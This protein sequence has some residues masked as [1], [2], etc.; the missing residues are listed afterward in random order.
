MLDYCRYVKHLKVISFS[1]YYY[2][3]EIGLT[4]NKKKTSE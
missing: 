4:Y 2:K 3:N 1:L